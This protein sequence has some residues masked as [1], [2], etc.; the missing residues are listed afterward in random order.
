[1]CRSR[2]LDADATAL[3]LTEDLRALLAALNK[4]ERHHAGPAAL[5]AAAVAD[6]SLHLLRSHPTTSERVDTLLS[7]AHFGIAH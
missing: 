4:L 7:L 6:R 1:L 2:E 5:A 3:E